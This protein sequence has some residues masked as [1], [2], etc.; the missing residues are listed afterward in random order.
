MTGR[1]RS[2]GRQGFALALVVFLLFAIGVAA[3]AAYEVVGGEFTLSR[4]NRESVTALSVARAGLQRFIAEQMGSVGDSVAYAIGDGIAT[5]TAR[6]VL[7]QDPSNYL[8]YI[9][10]DGTVTDPRMPSSPARRTVATYAWLR[11]AP[12]KQKAAVLMAANKVTYENA[13]TVADGS[14]HATAMDCAGGGTTGVAG[15]AAAGNILVQSGATLTGNPASQNYGTRAA[16]IDS[17]GIRWDILSNP[18]FPVEFDGSPPDWASIPADSFPVVRYVGDLSATSTWAGHGV[19]IV[20][21]TLTMG[22]GFTWQG[23]ILAGS[24]ADVGSDAPVVQGTLVGGLNGST[25]PVT[26]QSGTYWYNSCD[27][28]A[29]DMSLSYLDVMDRAVF[30]VNG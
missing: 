28:S 19:L 18:S 10:S 29:A 24:V 7:E 30:E 15:T 14:D 17:A 2:G 16:V 26:F 9:R 20:T 21:G 12:L 23:I 13:G 3:A 8:Y 11:T 6:R 22:T 5:V 1:R 25:G 4:E 27:V